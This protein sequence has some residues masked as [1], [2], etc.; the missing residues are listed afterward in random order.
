VKLT[1]AGRYCWRG[2]FTPTSPADL[3]GASDST[4]TECFTVNPVQPGLTTTAGAGPVAIGSAI[5]DTANL[6]GTANRHGTGGGGTDGSINPTTNGAVAGGTIT[7]NLYGPDDAN[8]SGS[9]LHTK[10]VNVSGDSST[11]NVYSDSFTPTSAGTYRWVASYSGDLPNT[12]SKSGACNDANESVVVSPAQPAIS[13]SQTTG[14]VPLG[15][16]IS[17]T[18][19]LSGTAKKPDG[20]AAGGTI[21]FKAYGPQ[22]DPA[23]PVCT[24]TAVYTS[25]AYA[26]SGD[27]LY[28]T[29]S[30]AAASFVPS[31]AGTYEWVA[32]YSGDLPNT[33]G[34]AS[35]CGDEASVIIQLQPTISTAQRFRPNDSATVAVG[36][37]SGGDLA[38][39][40]DFKLFVNN[41]TCSGT[42]DYDSGNIDITTGT[43]SG[44][45]RTVSSNNTTEY[46]TTG[47]T[48]SWLV[49]YTSTNTGHKNVTSTCN[50]EHSS[51]TIANG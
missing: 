39:N 51:I 41:S 38:G 3:T 15:S 16:T 14:P 49:T 6:T 9:I 35:K 29:A 10:T 32:T 31:A 37:S 40:V 26:V 42:A 5:S 27:G 44:T 1:E 11:S 17:D 2:D 33:L 36:S 20:T 22:A 13:T 30:Q 50:T 28:P 18:A 12:K 43:G 21:T 4:S 23:N 47:T 19:T 45:S 8:C 46:V 24:G 34:V 48:F 7:F 25:T